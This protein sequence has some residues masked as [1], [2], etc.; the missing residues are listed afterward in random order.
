LQEGEERGEFVVLDFTNNSAQVLLVYKHFT[1]SY[2]R[3]CATKL[4]WAH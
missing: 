4:K 2:S 1:T 3:K